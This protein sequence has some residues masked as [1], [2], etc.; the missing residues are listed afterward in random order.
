MTCSPGFSF[1]PGV[2]EFQGG[3]VF[4]LKKSALLLS[5]CH[6]TCYVI[7]WV[8]KRKLVHKEHQPLKC[9]IQGL[10]SP[11]FWEPLIFLSLLPI[12]FLCVWPCLMACWILVSRAGIKPVSTALEVQSLNHW[13]AREVPT[14][15]IWMDLGKALLYQIQTS[16]SIKWKLSRST[17]LSGCKISMS[18][19][20]KMF[21]IK[22]QLLL[23]LL[24][25][26]VFW[27]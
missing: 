15:F 26:Y 10:S 11:L 17:F 9:W 7:P 18:P 25:Y 23:L 1:V 5:V 22:Y 6:L 20:C 21:G 3:W 8:G 16:L 14:I 12:L 19:A 4:W 13:I 27:C 2:W 24:Y